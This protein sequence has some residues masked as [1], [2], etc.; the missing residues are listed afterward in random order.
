MENKHGAT[1]RAPKELRAKMGPVCFAT[2]LAL[3][4]VQSAGAAITADTSA[5]NQPGIHTSTSGATVVDINKASSEGVSH[6]IYSEFNVDKN[7]VVLNNSTTN[8]STQQAGNINGNANLA[9]QSATIILNEVRSSDPSQLNGMVEVAGQSAQVI[10]A[11]PSGITCDGCG[12]INT[13]HATLTTGTAN[14][15]DAGKLT[16]FDVQK[17]QVTITGA[18]MDVNNSGKPLMTDIYARSVKVNAKLQAN[19]LNIITG[20]NR[21]NTNGTVKETL[22]GIGAAPAVALDVSSLGSMYAGKITM[23]GTDTGVG[24]RLDHADITAQDRLSISTAGKIENNNSVIASGNALTINSQSLDNSNGEIRSD[25]GSLVINSRQDLNNHNGKISGYDVSVNGGDTNNT[26]G[27]IQ[28]KGNLSLTGFTLDNQNGV[29]SSGDDLSVNYNYSNHNDPSVYAIKNENG[30]M[31][32]AGN[33]F[34]QTVNLDNNSGLITADK[35]LSISAAKLVNTNSDNFVASENWKGVNQA[36]GIYAGDSE[37]ANTHSH[38]MTGES[39]ISVA[40]LDNEAGRIVSTGKNTDLHIMSSQVINNNEGIIDAAKS[41]TIDQRSQFNNGNGKVSAAQDLNIN[42]Y[43]FSSDAKGEIKANNINLH[44]SGTFNNSGVITASRDLLLNVGDAHSYLS[45]TSYNKGQITA[46]GAMTVQ[47]DMTNFVNEGTIKAGDALNWHGGNVI[48][49]GV[50]D[51]NSDIRFT[52]Q[53]LKNAKG[54]TID[55]K[56]VTISGAVDNQGTITPDYIPDNGPAPHPD[57]NGGHTPMPDP[58]PAPRPDDGGHTPI[59]D[60]TPSHHSDSQ[61]QSSSGS[62]STYSHH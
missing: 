48:N 10:I 34:I 35:A 5:A 51:S 26:D 8:T 56:S 59:P 12:F 53:S 3:G 39:I 33:M 22:E 31:A 28:S 4:M 25:A 17:G 50:I 58:A 15:D 54:A 55:G 7:G 19:N 52:V 42:A 37:G 32:S 2:L 23:V 40:S 24:V 43:D 6:N 9:G 61:S 44:T 1:F 62:S 41:L 13:N 60:Q 21:I 27:I 11:N 47:T 30:V 20:A 29:V 36:G 38:Y 45:E 46:G 57:D 18:G 16:G 14:F 49:K